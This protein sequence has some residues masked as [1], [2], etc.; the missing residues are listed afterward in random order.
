MELSVFVD[1]M[2]L[3]RR[4]LE[5][6][7]IHLPRII[8]R[9]ELGK[10]D[11]EIEKP[12][13]HKRYDGHFVPSEAPPDEL[14]LRS[15]KALAFGTGDFR[16]SKNTVRTYLRWTH[17]FVRFLNDC[18]VT[19]VSESSARLFLSEIVIKSNVAAA[20]QRQAFN[21]ILLLF[22]HVLDTEIHGLDDVVPSR[23]I[24]TLPVVLSPLEVSRVLECLSGTKWLFG[25]LI[26]GAGLRLGKAL[27]LR[28]QHIDFE[29]SCITVRQ[30]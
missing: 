29:R 8:R 27:E 14:S 1:E 15:D 18:D 22:R 30:A 13:Y 26:Y 9:Q 7:S 17:R 25:S 20:T 24:R 4:P 28:I 11:R 21:A 6:A 10:D 12:Q 3:C 5:K 23:K 16:L 19:A 2:D